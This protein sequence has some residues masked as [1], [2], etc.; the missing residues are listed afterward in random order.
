VRLFDGGDHRGCFDIIRADINTYSSDIDDNIAEELLLPDEFQIRHTKS[1]NP[2]T[3][4]TCYDTSIYG[5]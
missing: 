2:S 3:P 1:H 5:F 4:R